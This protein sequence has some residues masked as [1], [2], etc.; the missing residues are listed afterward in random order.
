MKKLG[1]GIAAAVV[2]LLAGGAATSYVM[3]GKVQ[4]GFEATAKRMEQAAAGHPG[5]ELRA[6]SFLVDCKD[7]V[8]RQH[9]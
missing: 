7:D 1:I 5:A 3:G 4:A 6:R 8:D 2:V 9:G